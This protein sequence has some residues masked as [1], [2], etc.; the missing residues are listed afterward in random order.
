MEAPIESTVAEQGT[1]M[2]R[3]EAARNPDRPGPRE[4]PAH[5]SPQPFEYPLRREFG[6]TTVR[7]EEPPTDWPDDW[8]ERIEAVGFRL[9]R[10][11]AEEQP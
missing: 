4:T 3:R 2:A 1:A 11:E 10:A 8:G 5:P 9:E 6:A 7:I